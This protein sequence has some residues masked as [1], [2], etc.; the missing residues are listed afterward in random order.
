MKNLSSKFGMAAVAVALTFTACETPQPND[1]SYTV[2]TTYNFDNVSYSGQT[3]RLNMMAEITTYIKTA[4]VA[5][6]PALSSVKLQ[7]MYGD[8]TGNH[9]TD[10]A[11]N[12]STKQLKNKTVVTAQPKFD[13]YL[14]AAALTSLNTNKTAAS[15]QAGIASNNAGTKH[16]LL[17]ANGI[18]W[19]QIIEKGLMGACFYYQGTA[20]Y[21]G[22]SKMNVDNTI[23]NAGEG[24]DMEHH[25][26][27]AFGYFGVPT[28][29]PTNTSGLVFWGKYCNKHESV[30][31]LN[32]KMMDGF[33]KG[34][35]AI[36]AKDIPTRDAQITEL[37][38]QWELVVAATAIYYLNNAKDN[39]GSDAAAA[40]HELSEVFG[41]IMSLKY[42]AGTG[43]ITTTQV[44]AI[45]TAL[46]G[47]SDPFIANTYNVTATKIEA[48]KTALTGYFADLDPVKNTL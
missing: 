13:S 37:R 28:D 18:E 36:S 42:G 12:T 24:T 27:E 38:K 10:A 1:N 11:L 17:N 41:F 7:D 21:M 23:V 43:S 39:L 5:N 6:A 46:F 4:H 22:D 45:L 33:L 16:Y 29:F 25:W 40:A 26:D 2:P 35:A 15:G 3:A 44:D 19:A 31:P 20:V 30:F 34:R 8:N 32:Q 9:F 48:A 47:N 14:A